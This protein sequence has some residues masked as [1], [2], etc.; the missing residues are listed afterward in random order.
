MREHVANQHWWLA[1]LKLREI[2]ENPSGL[3][4][5]PAKITTSNV[6]R[7]LL[8]PY[9]REELYEKAWS[10]PIQQLAKEYGISDVGLAKVCRKLAVPI[11]G[12]GYWAKKAAGKPVAKRPRLKP[13]E[14]A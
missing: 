8:S 1:R 13:L 11:P 14:K 7:E 3:K 5:E 4:R 6:S 2:V 9:N 12:R 10:K